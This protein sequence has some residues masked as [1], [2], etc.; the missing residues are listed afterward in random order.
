MIPKPALRLML[1]LV[2]ASLAITS[3]AVLSG[4]PHGGVPAESPVVAERSLI[5]R[6][7]SAQSV[8]IHDA[9]G[10]LLQALDHGGFVTVVGS[11]IDRERSVHRLPA[12]APVILQRRANGRF[13]ILDPS[14]GLGIE[15]TVFGADNE[16]AFAALLPAGGGA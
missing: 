14:T 5:L 12:D 7:G 16:A 15:L 11:A 13:S 4:A 10:R 1:A 6:T 2:L 9:D 3:F 8:A